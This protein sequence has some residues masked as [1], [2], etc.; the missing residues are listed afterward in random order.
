[1][2]DDLSLFGDEPSDAA[3]PSLPQSAP[4]ADWQRD[5]IR[6]ALDARGLIGMDERQKAVVE[7]AGRPLASL[8]DLTHD[9]AIALLSRLGPSTRT[10]DHSAS[11][12][13][14]REEDTW[15]DRL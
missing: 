14:S 11:S 5:L 3:V 4:I 8:R 13:D 1:M 7:A 15:I 2:T 10:G 9:E 6:K 12:W